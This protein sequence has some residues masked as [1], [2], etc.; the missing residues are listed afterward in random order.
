MVTEFGKTEPLANKVTR[1]IDISTEKPDYFEYKWPKPGIY[2]VQ[3][4]SV[5]YPLLPLRVL[6]FEPLTTLNVPAF[7]VV[8]TICIITRTRRMTAGLPQA[9]Y[10]RRQVRLHVVCQLFGI[11]EWEHCLP[12][13]RQSRKS[14]GRRCR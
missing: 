7:G 9:V 14:T 2:T 13:F 12:F 5:G 6:R 11:E 1:S 4:E 3:G 10:N 8:V